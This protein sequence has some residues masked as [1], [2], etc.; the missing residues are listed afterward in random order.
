MSSWKT[1]KKKLICAKCKNTFQNP[2]LLPC[3]DMICADC[4][5]DLLSRTSPNPSGNK[6][7]VQCP[8]CKLT[9]SVPLKAEDLVSDVYTQR[10]VQVLNSKANLRCQ[11]CCT[12][13]SV[14]A[15]CSICRLIL[16]KACTE[17][18]KRAVRTQEH[19]LLLVDEM[20]NSTGS[21]PTILF[22]EDESCPIHPTK[23]LTHYCRR[24]GE[25][26]CEDCATGKHANHNP[27]KIDD[28]L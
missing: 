10:L 4:L 3:L 18:H 19:E 6:K 24:E 21:T 1:L 17:A 9:V 28:A 20:R 15:I 14:F 25:L 2:K 27:T 23:L 12:D 8:Q 13:A 16:C 11:N 5:K 26:L 22:E 7:D